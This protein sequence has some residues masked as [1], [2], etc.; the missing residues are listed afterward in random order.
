MSSEPAS[1]FRSPVITS[2]TSAKP[3]HPIIAH[4]KP[5]KPY[6]H[7]GAP[8]SFALYSYY[9]SQMGHGL[10][11]QQFAQIAQPSALPSPH[12]LATSAVFAAN[13]VAAITANNQTQWDPET[14][15]PVQR[16]PCSPDSPQSADTSCSRAPQPS[17]SPKDR[18]AMA[19]T[20]PISTSI[21]ST[22][23][24]RTSAPDRGS[25]KFSWLSHY[26]V[27]TNAAVASAAAPLPSSTLSSPSLTS[28]H[29]NGSEATHTWNGRAG[30]HRPGE[31]TSAFMVDYLDDDPLLCAICSDK[32][33]GLHYGIYTCEGCKGFFKR[34]VQNKRVYTCVSGTGS[35]PMTKEQRNRCQFCRFQKCLQ[36]GMVLEAVREDRM[37]G[38]RNGSAI[39]NLYKLK[40]K[41]TRR[42]QA[43]CESILRENAAHGAASLAAA[44]YGSSSR[45][46]PSGRSMSGSTPPSG[47]PPSGTPAPEL[48]SSIEPLNLSAKE[49]VIKG[50]TMPGSGWCSSSSSTVSRLT[51]S[52]RS[53]LPPQNKNLIQELI[54]IDHIERLI[55]LKG[56]RIVHRLE[57]CSNDATTPACQR[58]S[59]IGD[60]IVEQL[61]EW[62]KMLPFYHELPVEVHTH[63][64]T[65]R[66]AE[67]VDYFYEFLH[68]C[69]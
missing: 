68:L 51:P 35:C 27:E 28:V 46:T 58:L 32:S 2:S 66:W 49:S 22:A 33:S 5:I 30:G 7:P 57:S 25:N 10:D 18:I 56:L 19:T 67:L 62:A 6:P 50:E 21:N 26:N 34:T 59:R 14:T 13:P 11:M 8:D 40:Y 39:Y 48:R 55:N 47:S 9:L 1:A 54:E 24:T 16:E 64:L 4:P 37:P 44:P 63:L 20:A 3:A 60:E 17:T 23:T 43:L 53:L 42:L 12:S 31:F 15:R 36:Q 38:G 52:T 45:L 65:Q 69:T 41:K 29:S 61:V